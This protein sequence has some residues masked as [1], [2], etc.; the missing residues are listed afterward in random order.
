MREHLRTIVSTFVETE[1]NRTA[2]ITITGV[3]LSHDFREATFL[4]S[5]LPQEHEEEVLH[6]LRRKRSAC[7]AY[8]KERLASKTIPFVDFA[9]DEGEKHRQR[10]DALLH[11]DI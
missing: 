8:V 2:L 7:R 4:I 10:I 11:G 1:S 6:F 9:L 5:V 3:T